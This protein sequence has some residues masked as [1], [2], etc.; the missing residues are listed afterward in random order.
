MDDPQNLIH[1]AA[2]TKPDPYKAFRIYFPDGSRQGGIWT[3]KVWW[4]ED[5]A[6]YPEHWQQLPAAEPDR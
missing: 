2:Q 6:V 5:R 3:G 1:D 4:S